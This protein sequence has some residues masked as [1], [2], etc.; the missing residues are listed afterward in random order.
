MIVVCS[1]RKKKSTHLDLAYE[2][3]MGI[4]HLTSNPSTNQNN[5]RASKTER[6]QMAAAPFF[7]FLI[8]FFF[9]FSFSRPYVILR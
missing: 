6:R 9:F 5:A 2:D 7:L 4:T 3:G 1:K 8:F